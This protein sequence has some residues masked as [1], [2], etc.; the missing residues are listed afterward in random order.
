MLIRIVKT[1]AAALAAIYIAQW[2]GLLTPF[3][4]GLLAIL[5]IDVTKKKSLAS[6]SIRILASAAGLVAACVIFRVFGFQIWGIGLFLL[7]LYPILVKA[8]LQDGIVTSTVIMLHLFSARRTDIAM[9]GNELGLLLIGFGVATVINMAYTPKAYR[10]L[11]EGKIRLEESLS[12]IF[13]QMAGHLR[14]PEQVWD[15]RELLEAEAVI[16]EGREAARLA[17][18][19]SLFRREEPWEAYYAMRGRQLD[20]IKRMLAL[21]AQAYE[22]VPHAAEIAPL[23]EGLS[24]DVKSEG[25]RGKVEERLLALERQFKEMPLPVTRGEF[26]VR[27]ALLQLMLELKAYLAIAKRSKTAIRRRS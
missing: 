10:R 25:Y 3:S 7:V 21:L 9:I 2:A 8:R 4:A 15:G 22:T 17:A 18:D 14:N 6:A 24:E 23:F 12:G 16:R 27:S 5:G 13:R 20:S 26:E 1:A 11:E 19:N